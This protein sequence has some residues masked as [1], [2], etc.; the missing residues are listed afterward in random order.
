MTKLGIIAG[1]GAL[2]RQIADLSRAQGRDVFIIALEGYTDLATV[3]GH[4]HAWV[5]LGAVGNTLAQLRAEAV[6]DLVLAGP[7]RRPSL[8]DLRPDL[9][10]LNLLRKFGKKALGDDGLLSSILA[11]LEEEGFHIVGADTLLGS[12]LAEPGSIGAHAP[13]DQARNDIERGVSVLI[14]LS[15]VDVGQAVVVQEGLVLG[16]EAIEGT[17][18]LLKRCGT[19]QREG[20]GGVLVK[21]RKLGQDDRVDLPTI[22]VETIRAA[23]RA[24]LRGVA[25]EAG[26]TMIM[27]R[28][29]MILEADEKGLFVTAIKVPT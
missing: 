15:N 9:T 27:E 6:S 16:V 29:D 4:P 14:A 26:G 5:R 2:P 25:I 28:D 3:E 11:T 23:S 8:A 1:G 17:D 22:G 12:V 10:A 24:G 20:L 7:V 13:D 19:L 18:A 21:I